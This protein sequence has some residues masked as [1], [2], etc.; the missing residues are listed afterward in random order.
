MLNFTITNTERILL[1]LFPINFCSQQMPKLWSNRNVQESAGTWQNRE[2]L[3]VLDQN[4][5]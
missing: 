5:E 3:V 4:L 2:D 1:E